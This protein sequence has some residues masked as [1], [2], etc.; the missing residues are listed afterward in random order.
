MLV[1]VRW[2]RALRGGCMWTVRSAWNRGDLSASCHQ[3]SS[4]ESCFCG[5]F[6]YPAV[7][8]RMTA[9]PYFKGSERGM[10]LPTG[11]EMLAFVLYSGAA[12]DERS[13]SAAVSR[14][15]ASLLLMLRSGQ[16]LCALGGSV[17]GMVTCSCPSAGL[18]HITP[19]LWTVLLRPPEFRGFLLSH[20]SRVT[21][22]A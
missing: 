6:F 8:F 16:A 4:T 2:K 3:L 7:N 13:G 20:G 15:A 19:G 14:C 10:S 5:Y 21:G 11:C 18:L 12:E 17:Q 9:K 1:T 22:L